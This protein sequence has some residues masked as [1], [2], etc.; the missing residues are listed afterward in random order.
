VKKTKADTGGRKA[1][2]KKQSQPRDTR[3]RRDTRRDA[4]PAAGEPWWNAERP[5]RPE[6]RWW[7]LSAAQLRKLAGDALRGLGELAC[8]GD[9]EAAI[10][11]VNIGARC[12]DEA[13]G[14]LP[15][16]PALQAKLT[17]AAYWP[18][19]IPASAAKRNRL[20]TELRERG[21]ASDCELNEAGKA[22]GAVTLAVQRVWELI[23]HLRTMKKTPHTILVFRGNVSPEQGRAWRTWA[24]AN[25]K[26]IP[27]RPTKQN[28][29]E[30]A[31]LTKPLL[32]IFWGEDFENH[33][34]FAERA[35]NAKRDGELHRDNA[36]TIRKNQQLAI[37][38][39]WE[40]S[41][42]S[43]AQPG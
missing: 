16:S 19:C 30:L 34:D 4:K 26:K 23:R 22:R 29:P 1:K 14:L 31:K 18:V 38:D 2:V 43:I 28:A 33:P 37:I 25:A 21:F 27:Q 15:E 12:A 7:K 24:I 32:S 17:K 39:S 35:K 6:L 9:S 8:K 5:D 20:V 36:E 40:Q 3:D 41:W 42:G 10:A 11:L 13:D